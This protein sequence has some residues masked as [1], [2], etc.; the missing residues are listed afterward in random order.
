MRGKASQP[1]KRRC[2]TSAEA[3]KTQLVSI[4][5]RFSKWLGGAKLTRLFMS[6]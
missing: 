6:Q 5:A 2:Q 1:P 4:F 3:S